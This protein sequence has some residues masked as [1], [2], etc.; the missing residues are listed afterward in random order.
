MGYVAVRRLHGNQTYLLAALLAH[1]LNRELQMVTR[2]PERRT[3]GTRPA[4]WAFQTLATIR[5]TLVQRAG[6]LTR[7]NGRLTLTMSANEEVQHELLTLLAARPEA[8]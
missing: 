6:R 3:T 1:S 5:R 8:A 2:P 4:L 7:P